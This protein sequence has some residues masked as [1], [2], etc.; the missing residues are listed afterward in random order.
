MINFYNHTIL[1][2]HGI[3]RCVGMLLGKGAGYMGE[4][5]DVEFW[6]GQLLE[7]LI[8]ENDEDETYVTQVMNAE[9]YFQIQMP[10]TKTGVPI[11]LDSGKSVTIHFYD[12]VHGMCTFDSRIIQLEDGNTIIKKPEPEAIKRIQRRRFFRVNAAVPLQIKLRAEEEESEDKEWDLYTHDISGG[13]VSFLNEQE[14]LAE[15]DFLHG[16]ME[17]KRANEEHI[18]DFTAKVV[19]IM[20]QINNFYKIS[21]EFQEVTEKERSEII[22]YCMFKQIE[23][24]KKIGGG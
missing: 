13:G 11:K 18:V 14:I 15:N 1:K 12:D 16:T 19:N 5:I 9:R 2:L 3:I 22:R 20:K 21:L 17:L 4:N 6:N 24:R 23:N 7:V 10:K 8:S